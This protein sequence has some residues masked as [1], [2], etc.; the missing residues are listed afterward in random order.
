MNTAILPYA[1]EKLGKNVKLK[2]QNQNEIIIEIPNDYFDKFTSFFE[3]FDQDL[4]NL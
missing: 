3:A 1:R 2:S 4:E